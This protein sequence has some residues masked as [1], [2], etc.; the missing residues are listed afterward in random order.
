MNFFDTWVKSID[1][2]FFNVINSIAIFLPR[3]LS[4]VIIFIIGII[5]AN[6]VSK[7]VKALF[8]KI[9]FIDKSLENTGFKK[10]FGQAGFE[11]NADEIVGWLVY[12][13]IMIIFLIAV[14]DTLNLPQISMFIGLV[15][16]Y[17]PNVIAAAVILFIGIVLADF[18]GRMI[19]GAAGAAR[20]PTIRAISTISRWAIIIFTFL[21]ALNQLKIDQSLIQILF[22]GIVAALAIGLGISFG[23]G[24]VDSARKFID[25][26]TQT[27]GKMVGKGRT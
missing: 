15:A 19:A 11:L 16:S 20:L 13:F 24:G 22:T 4:A 9:D 6:L 7:I 27:G 23:L 5:L 25:Q 18:V 14:A 17:L 2:A 21:S 8:A 26:M 12:W 10:A 1:N 3:I